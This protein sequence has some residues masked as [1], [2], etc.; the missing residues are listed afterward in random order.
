MPT[1]APYRQVTPADVHEW[2]GRD[3]PVVLVDVRT[4]AEYARR[5]IPGVILLPLDEF[6]A[7]AGELN[8]AD[9]IICICEH[10]IRSEM[11]AQYLASLGYP[12]VATMTGGM[13]AYSSPTESER[14]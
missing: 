9:E 13:A 12:R 14:R 7:R 4:P 10:G 2:V 3:A 6:A 5:H 8:P 11:T 1:D